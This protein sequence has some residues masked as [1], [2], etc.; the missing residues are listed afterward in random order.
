MKRPIAWRAGCTLVP[1]DTGRYVLKPP[2]LRPSS[3]SQVLLKTPAKNL[4]ITLICGSGWGAFKGQ[5]T[6]SAPDSYVEIAIK[7][8]ARAEDEGSTVESS[9]VTAKTQKGC[10]FLQPHLR[11]FMKRHTP[12]PPPA[13]GRPHVLLLQ[14]QRPAHLQAPTRACREHTCQA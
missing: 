2:H 9:V 7:G 3:N 10:V 4:A 13:R 6:F 5:D 8:S 12:A 11:A 1:C 14:G